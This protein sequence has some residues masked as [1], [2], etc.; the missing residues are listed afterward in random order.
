MPSEVPT[1]GADQHLGRVVDALKHELERKS[2]ELA[3]AREQQAATAGI[4]AAL[5]SSPADLRGVC[6]EIAANAARLCDAY[7][8]G[9][10]QCAGDQ[11]RLVA[12]RGHIP[13]LTHIAGAPVWVGQ[14]TLPLSRGVV[15]GRA[16]LDRTILQVPDLQAETEEY[17]EGSEF[18]RRL[19]HRAILA[20]P[21][22]RGQEAIGA[23][24]V[25]RTEARPFTD[26]QIE[27]LKTFAD[28]AIIAIENTRLFEEVQARTRELTEALEQ[29]TATSQV[30]QVISSSPGDLEPVFEAML[31]NAVRVSGAKFGFMHLYAGGAFRTVAMHNA[32][33]AF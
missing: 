18:A 23:I 5:S 32:P 29:Q 7:D 28:Q 13:Y 31:S 30:L 4:L 33:P 15:I 11:L 19:G 10:L 3:E 21:L 22:I 25:R 20:V 1:A 17:P 9:V 8:A 27:L 16:V 26:R 24:F 12:H 2:R 14:G 6:A